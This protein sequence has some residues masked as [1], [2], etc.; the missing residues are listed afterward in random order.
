MSL[1]N[2]IKTMRH[3]KA[4]LLGTGLIIATN[5]IVLAGVAY[6]RSGEPD[7]TITLT[8]RELSLPYYYSGNAENSGIELQLIHRFGNSSYFSS[9][10]KSPEIFDWFNSEKL[11]ELGFDV[12]QAISGDKDKRHYQKLREKEVVLVL[13][14][15]GKA[16]QSVLEEA[17]KQYDKVLA[18][19]STEQNSDNQN[20]EK[21]KNKNYKLRQAEQNLTR[22][23]TS[24]SRLFVIDAGLDRNALRTKYADRT[25]YLL[26]KGVVMAHITDDS[27]SN[28]RLVGYINSLSN[29]YIHV[30]LQ[31]HAVI[32]T[33]AAE[34]TQRKPDDS[35]RYEATINVGQRLE[36]WLVGVKGLGGE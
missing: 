9:D 20:N 28:P 31:Y 1:L 14:Y 27:S 19:Q 21:D 16:Y 30:P 24:A 25:K 4:L 36:P 26:M 33:A 8:E 2:K 13:E 3:I 10:Y 32:E 34:G 35:P 12:S 23:K 5:A 17:Q 29:P 22:E 11:A 7:S 6:N 15:N 18:E